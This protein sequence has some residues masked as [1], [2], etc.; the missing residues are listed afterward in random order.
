MR[1][2]YAVADLACESSGSRSMPT[3]NLQIPFCCVSTFL[4]FVLTSI[5]NGQIPNEKLGD[6]DA[7]ARVDKWYTV[8]DEIIDSIQVGQS[9]PP[10]A[11]MGASMALPFHG[12]IQSD[13]EMNCW[14]W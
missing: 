10:S 11:S 8:Y 3:T 6:D 1:N 9:S 2:T 4:I 5:A 12:A 13:I 7:Q 14:V